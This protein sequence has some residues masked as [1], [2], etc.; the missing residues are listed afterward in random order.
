M[1]L[2]SLFGS[3]TL[4]LSWHQNYLIV[5]EAKCIVSLSVVLYIMMHHMEANDCSASIPR[6][7]VT[8]CI[9]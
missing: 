6:N 7:M 4:Y 5:R 1:M 9:L 8:P 2:L 3:P